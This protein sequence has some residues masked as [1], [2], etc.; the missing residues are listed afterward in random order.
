MDTNYFTG[1]IVSYQYVCL[2]LHHIVA[3]LEGQ[4]VWITGA[5]TGIGAACA[6]EA[7]KNGAKVVLSARSK[8]K[9]EDVQKK[10]IGK[11]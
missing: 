6:I 4:V 9:L 7:A 10:C 11:T 3:H 1:Y 5:S 8:D 2:F